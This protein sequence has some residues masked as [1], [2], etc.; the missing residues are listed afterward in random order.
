[1]DCW[2]CPK[3]NYTVEEPLL[4][5]PVPLEELVKS[6][7]SGQSSITPFTLT[8]DK[9][10]AWKW[11]ASTSQ[12]ATGHRF[13]MDRSSEQ[14]ATKNKVKVSILVT[15]ASLCFRT[16]N[17]LGPYLGKCLGHCVIIPYCTILLFLVLHVQHLAMSLRTMKP[18]N[19]KIL[20]PYAIN[21]IPQ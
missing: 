6:L 15:K 1:M 10:W 11:R 13:H 8:P 4:G 19:Q 7:P 5:I 16:K 12:P 2:L 3:W 9:W 17:G 18:W 20:L 21:W 14:P